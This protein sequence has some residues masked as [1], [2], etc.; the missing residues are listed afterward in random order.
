M[1]RVLQCS[2]SMALVLLAGS[3]RVEAKTTKNLSK[4]MADSTLVSEFEGPAVKKGISVGYQYGFVEY[5]EPGL[6][7]EFGSLHGINFSYD[8]TLSSHYI[9][10]ES[11]LSAGNLTYSGR[12]WGGTPVTSGTKDWILNLRGLSAWTHHFSAST[13]ANWYAG[14]GYRYLNDKIQGSGGYERETTYVY[15]P[16]GVGLTRQLNSGWSIG[17]NFEYDVFL[18]GRVKSHL[19]DSSSG[20]ADVENTQSAGFGARV[21][22]NLRKDFRTYAIKIQPYYQ[23]WHIKNSDLVQMKSQSGQVIVS[24]NGS[25]MG[26]L[27]PENNSKM[28]GLNVIAEL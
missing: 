7:K 16:V 27:E 3:L 19:S 12:T 26:V 20:I 28:I 9:R 10:F 14:L 24:D 4:E 13:M 23:Y 21:N 18:T 15:F 22:M 8:W 2:V 25:P 6:M 17:T 1:N 11:D 5:L